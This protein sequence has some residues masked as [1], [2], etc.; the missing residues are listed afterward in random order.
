[1]TVATQLVG[2][3]L[4]D[5]LISGGLLTGAKQAAGQ[6]AL[7]LLSGF[8]ICFG[9]GFFLLAAYW[10]LDVA[11]TPEM[12][13]LTA[14]VISFGLAAIIGGIMFLMAKIRQRKAQRLQREI[15][16]LLT[17]LVGTVDEDVSNA[18]RENPKTAALLAFLTGYLASDRVL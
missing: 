13:A 16:D 15:A 14:G 3:V 18:I 11:N 6:G 1:M 17:T 2:H 12:S 9:I 8:L 4:V 5:K 7:L 10:R